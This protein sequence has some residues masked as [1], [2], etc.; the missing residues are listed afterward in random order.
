[1]LHKNFLEDP[2]P[3]P[4]PLPP[5]DERVL[6]LLRKAELSGGILL[7]ELGSSK[8]G[9][10]QRYAL[11]IPYHVSILDEWNSRSSC[12]SVWPKSPLMTISTRSRRH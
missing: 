7:R 3:P 4:L 12:K 1:M 11:M 2:L 5:P 8:S 6:P 9:K 10:D